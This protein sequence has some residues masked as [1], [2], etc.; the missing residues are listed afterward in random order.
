MFRQQS[1]L[2]VILSVSNAHTQDTSTTSHHRKSV[3]HIFFL[4]D[5]QSQGQHVH[6]MVRSDRSIAM[7][8]DVMLISHVDV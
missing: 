2:P 3:P 6:T 4:V 8:E 1:V 7:G 5:A